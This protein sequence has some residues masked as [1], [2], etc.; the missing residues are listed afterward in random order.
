VQFFYSKSD[1]DKHN[2]TVRRVRMVLAA[3][4]ILLF[5]GMATSRVYGSNDNRG[6]IQY[7]HFY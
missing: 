1:F 7:L 3:K 6:F 4:Q 2:V 5:S